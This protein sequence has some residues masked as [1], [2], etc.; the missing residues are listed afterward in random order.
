MQATLDTTV[1]MQINPAG[2]YSTSFSYSSAFKYRPRCVESSKRSIVRFSG[3]CGKKQRLKVEDS[4]NLGKPR[5][6]DDRCLETRQQNVTVHAND[7]NRQYHRSFCTCTR[8][9]RTVMRLCRVK[10]KKKKKTLKNAISASLLTKASSMVNHFSGGVMTRN[11]YLRRHIKS[12][13][14]VHGLN[15]RPRLTSKLQPLSLSLSLSLSLV[16]LIHI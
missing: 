10:K 2:I 15:N 6:Q 16:S 14:R 9:N 1:A 13:S 11:G 8:D 7:G 3:V 4:S 12:V 5:A